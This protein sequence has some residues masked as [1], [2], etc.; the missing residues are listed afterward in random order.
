MPKFE[1]RPDDS[2]DPEDLIFDPSQLEAPSTET[3]KSLSSVFEQLESYAGTSYAK[4]VELQVG[5]PDAPEQIHVYCAEHDRGGGMGSVLTVRIKAGEEFINFGPHQPQL[6]ESE[7]QTADAVIDKLSAGLDPQ[8]EAWV[9]EAY[10]DAQHTDDDAL[11]DLS[12]AALLEKSPYPPYE[13]THYMVNKDFKNGTQVQGDWVRSNEA[14]SESMP[15][16]EPIRSL[17]VQT[18]GK[19]YEYSKT[20]S[21]TVRLLVK[22]RVKAQVQEGEDMQDAIA[23]SFS[24]DMAAHNEARNVGAD[25]PT[26]GSMRKMVDL[27]HDAIIAEDTGDADWDSLLK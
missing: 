15:P 8:Q 18:S 27:V 7:K 6:K 16:E 12:V 22:E 17:Y 5:E 13:H 2:H 14:W 10:A 19:V 25:I 4:G 24:V 21:D 11:Q 3:E 9:R 1:P 20:Y 26:E 23:R